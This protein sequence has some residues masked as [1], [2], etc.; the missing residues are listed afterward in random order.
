MKPDRNTFA[1]LFDVSSDVRA[2]I[3]ARERSRPK[4][5]EAGDLFFLK[6]PVPVPVAWCSVFP[7]SKDR[8]LWYCVPG[9]SYS[10][11]SATDVSSPAS[12]VRDELHF[13]CRCGLWVH[14]EDIDLANRFDRLDVAEVDSI[15]TVISELSANLIAILFDDEVGSD[16]DY[17]EWI[18]AL[19]LAV[20]TLLDSL[21]N[22][23][24]H[25]VRLIGIESVIAHLGQS[26]S[27]AA[28][29]SATPVSDSTSPS[30]LQRLQVFDSVEGSLQACL[31][32]D[33]VIVEWHPARIDSARPVVVHDATPMEW[34]SQETFWCTHLI[35]WSDD[36]LQLSVNGELVGFIKPQD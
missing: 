6:M 19:R 30:L 8:D 5:L 11:A 26:L 1:N 23:E 15:R 10:L 22:E 14:A 36:R 7:H 13:R 27:L 9:D 24:S 34:V 12:P 17:I 20:D 28:D 35:S 25:S 4:R 16:P 29:D 2:Q 32:G 33:G 18:D 21:H 31:Y 3:S